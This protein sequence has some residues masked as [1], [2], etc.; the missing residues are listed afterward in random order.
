MTL[1]VYSKIL[2]TDIQLSSPIRVR[3]GV[4]L[5]V[6][7]VIWECIIMIPDCTDCREKVT[8]FTH[9][10]PWHQGPF[11]YPIFDFQQRHPSK[12]AF[13]TFLQEGQFP[14]FSYL[15]NVESIL[16]ILGWLIQ[17]DDVKCWTLSRVTHDSVLQFAKQNTGFQALLLYSKRHEISQGLFDHSE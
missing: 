9:S 16:V 10:W 11:Q 4:Y 5:R 7:R 17:L 2:T 1:S 14:Q 6:N 13:T 15:D 3:Y 12:C 8:T